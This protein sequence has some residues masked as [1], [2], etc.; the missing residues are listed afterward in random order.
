MFRALLD[1]GI[2]RVGTHHAVH[3]AGPGIGV[4]V[5]LHAEVQLVSLRR[6][7]HFR[8]T[9][10]VLILGRTRR[11]D[12]RSIYDDAL[13]Q[14]QTPVA[15]VTI[16][17]RQNPGRQ[18]VLLQQATEIDDGGFVGNTRQVQPGKLAQDCG[19]VQRLLHRRIA[20]AE[21]VLHQMYAQH[22]HQR[23]RRTATFTL[24]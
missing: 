3:Q 8:V 10:A 7:V 13:A 9:L 11:M 23:I 1:A 16:D 6:L 20:V 19:L 21:P 18:L 22:R 14:R 2:T 5:R 4:D 15:Q 17:H 24:G 12:Q